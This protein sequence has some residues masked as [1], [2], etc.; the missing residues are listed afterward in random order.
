LMGVALP[1]ALPFVAIGIKE[2]VLLGVGAI[3]TTLLVWSLTTPSGRVTW[4]RIR[5]WV[6]TQ[7]KAPVEYALNGIKRGLGEVAEAWDSFRKGLKGYIDWAFDYLWKMHDW[8]MGHIYDYVVPRIAVLENWRKAFAGWFHRE[9]EAKLRSGLQQLA[10]LWVQF[11][12]GVLKVLPEMQQKL[13]YY[14]RWIIDFGERKILEISAELAKLKEVVTANYL[15]FTKWLDE[16][17]AG[18]KS[19]GLEL[20]KGL[21]SDVLPRIG[22]VLKDFAGMVAKAT[23]LATLISA[24][25]ALLNRLFD[26]IARE[27]KPDID[28]LTMFELDPLLLAYLRIT[29]S[30]VIDRADEIMN[31]LL[32]SYNRIMKA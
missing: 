27:L 4:S 8:I 29:K 17:K 15:R 31:S 23:G 21:T 28:F 11:R 7:V 18:V 10:E 9:I 5:A 22:S 20:V 24:I 14:G 6:E 2:L 19:F 3:A 13:S 32:D 16:I 25:G 26:E 12:Q 30:V 1:V